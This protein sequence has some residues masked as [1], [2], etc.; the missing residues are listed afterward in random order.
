MNF[1][2]INILPKD[3]KQVISEKELQVGEL[4]MLLGTNKLYTRNKSGVIID[5]SGATDEELEEVELNYFNKTVDTLDNVTAGATNIHFTTTNDSELADSFKKTTDDLDDITAGTTNKHF[6]DTEKTKLSGIETGADV[7]ASNLGAA[8]FNST[9][10]VNPDDNDRFSLSN[11][12]DAE[13]RYSLWS[14][15]KATLKTYFDTLYQNVF[16]GINQTKE[17]SKSINSSNGTNTTVLEINVNN[18]NISGL[19]ILEIFLSRGNRTN[20]GLV[21][22]GVFYI[23][24]ARRTGFDSV[25]QYD[26]INS[27]ISSGADAGGAIHAT[28]N[29]PTFS[30]SGSSSDTQSVSVNI[31]SNLGGGSTLGTFVLYARSIS[32]FT[33]L[34]LS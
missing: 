7:T 26:S 32:Q 17:I 23:S 34:T 11:G 18:A 20:M 22:I 6:T 4:V 28:L 25:A 15:I 5:L 19:I 1:Q 9:E 14:Q 13:S 3:S 27:F 30:I 10:E 2:R 8:I 24:I 29:T 31:V 12:A 16:T 21:S 33:T